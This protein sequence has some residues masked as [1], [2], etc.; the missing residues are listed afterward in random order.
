M[1]VQIHYRSTVAPRLCHSGVGVVCATAGLAGEDNLARAIR[2]AAAA[3]AAGKQLTAA[4]AEASAAAAAAAAANAAAAKA[5]TAKPV[6]PR[7]LPVAA[8]VKA[9]LLLVALSVGTVDIQSDPR[10]PSSKRSRDRS[11]SP[12]RAPPSVD[13]AH[14]QAN[15]KEIDRVMLGIEDAAEAS[16]NRRLK[17]QITSMRWKFADVRARFD[18]MEVCGPRVS[19]PSLSVC[20][21]GCPCL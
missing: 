13:H 4:K 9:P 6:T 15:A 18:A 14:V 11:S 3:T 8:P 16:E 19:L 1:Y 10:L 17:D 21:C 7:A 2:A 5:S 20:V 12:P